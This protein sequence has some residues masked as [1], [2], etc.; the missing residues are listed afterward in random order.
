ML[1]GEGLLILC[2]VSGLWR[3]EFTRF[4]FAGIREVVSVY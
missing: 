3:G 4:F 1:K 2:G